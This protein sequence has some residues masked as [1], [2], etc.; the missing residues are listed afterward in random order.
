MGLPRK[1]GRD[2]RRSCPSKRSSHL[3]FALSKPRNIARVE[4][5]RFENRYVERRVLYGRAC[6]FQ[7]RPHFFR[8]N[9]IG[10]AARDF[11]KG[12]GS[13][14]CWRSMPIWKTESPFLVGQAAW[15]EQFG[16]LLI[17]VLQKLLRGD[18]SMRATA[19]EL[20][21]SHF[22][23]SFTGIRR[24]K[25]GDWIVRFPCCCPWTHSPYVRRRHI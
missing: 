24:T 9:P 8:N 25:E 15:W 2:A 12:V 23:A 6:Q 18:P 17:P 3:H 1:E 19:A 22:G 14:E 7:Y 10:H 11:Y 16:G 4:P 21:S 5:S 13:C 20:V